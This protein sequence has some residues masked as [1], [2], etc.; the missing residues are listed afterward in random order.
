MA[1]V[2]II[3]AG[4]GGTSILKALNGIP[5]INIIGMCDV[6]TNSEGMV[7]ARQLGVPNYTDIKAMLALPAL[8]LVIEA[9]GSPRVQE[10]INE[11]KSVHTAIVDSHGANLM[12]T[13]VESR[14]DMIHSLHEEA[15]R[16]ADM[17]RDLSNTIQEI[18]RVIEEVAQQAHTTARQGSQLISSSREAEQSLTETGEVLKIISS[19]AQQTKLL[20]FNAAI[21]A[22]RSGEHGR[23]FA[24]VADEVRKLAEFSTVSA[25][26]ISSILSN[27]EHAFTTIN[28]GI[29]EAGSTMLKQA[30]LTESAA[31][32]IQE[33]EAMSEE[34]L[35]TA[36]N[37][38][39]L[40]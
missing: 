4:K 9:T 20:G 35:A 34:L 18:R 23:G 19:T 22:A 27:I 40:G 36:D 1:N 7:L 37:L 11:S 30:K 21:E 8:E 26:K 32:N 10:M 14:E 17:S 38:T 2:A 31:A 13:L 5:A 24:V 28:K 6:N 16:L 25:Q 12:M 3:G 39:K 15:T 29:D 33:L